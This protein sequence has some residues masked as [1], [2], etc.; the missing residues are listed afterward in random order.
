MSILINGRHR[1]TRQ[2]AKALFIYECAHAND[3]CLDIRHFFRLVGLATGNIII[4]IDE[5]NDSFMISEG[6]SKVEAKQS[7]KVIHSKFDRDHSD[8]ISMADINA[9]ANGDSGTHAYFISC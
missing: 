7:V 4:S 1:L 9:Q 2:S 6:N 3:V 5:Q 8:E